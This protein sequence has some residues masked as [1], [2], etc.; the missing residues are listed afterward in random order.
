[1]AKLY[2]SLGEHTKHIA[3]RILAAQAGDNRITTREFVG[4]AQQIATCCYRVLRDWDDLSPDEQV[5]EVED[6]AGRLFDEHLASCDWPAVDGQTEADAKASGREAIVGT[7]KMAAALLRL[8][9]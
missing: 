5:A 3:D 7:A 9:G 8:V 2:D 1:M 4:I 6:A